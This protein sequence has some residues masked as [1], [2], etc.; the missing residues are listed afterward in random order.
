MVAKA[1]DLLSKNKE[2]YFLFVEGGRIDHGHHATKAQY[3]LDEAAE[4]SKAIAYA[5]RA[6]S[7]H[8]T[9]IVVTADH[10]HTMSYSGYPARGNNIFGM[11]GV[12]E[13]DNLPYMTLSYAN[14]LGSLLHQH[15]QGGRVNPTTLD[16]N[17]KSFTF[18]AT[19]PLSSE[20]HGGDDAAVYATGPW[21]HLFTGTFEQNVIPH[22]MAYA[23]CIGDGL[24]ACDSK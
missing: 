18:P 17:H 15:P 20:T 22:L 24:K 2:G 4:F 13:K 19:V 3:A 21:S 14:G 8:D 10:A 11:A 23:A 5:R 12:S 9:L 16:Y 1:I 6:V 7:D